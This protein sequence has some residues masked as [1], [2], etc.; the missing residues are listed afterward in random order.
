MPAVG[1]PVEPAE[2]ALSCSNGSQLLQPIEI[3]R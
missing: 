1:G 2:A 3:Y